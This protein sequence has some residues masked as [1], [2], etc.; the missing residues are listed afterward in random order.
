M[1]HGTMQL[2]QKDD[3]AWGT[4]AVAEGRCV[5]A[6]QCDATWQAFRGLPRYLP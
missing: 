1:I 2:M 4:G 3:R 5:D 6:P